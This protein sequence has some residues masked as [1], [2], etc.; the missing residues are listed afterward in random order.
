MIT[1]R[2]S[3]GPNVGSIVVHSRLGQDVE[4]IVL[5]FEELQGDALHS[6]PGLHPVVNRRYSEH[7]GAAELDAGRPQHRVV[8]EKGTPATERRRHQNDR[9][10]VIAC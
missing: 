5:E 3:N 8:N 2:A 7:R 1:A 10:H 4:S 6:V 9:L